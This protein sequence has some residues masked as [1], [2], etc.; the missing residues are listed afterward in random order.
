MLR[1]SS[2]KRSGSNNLCKLSLPNCKILSYADDTVLL[3]HGADWDEAR[4]YAELALVI[5]MKWLQRNLLTLNIRKTNFITFAPNSSSL[6]PDSFKLHAHQ[7]HPL[8]HSGCN[9]MQ[10]TRATNVKYLGVWIDYKLSWKEHINVTVGRVRKLIYVFKNLRAVLEIKTLRTIYFALCKSILS[11]CI[12]VWGCSA[13]SHFLR[14]ER[15]QRAILKVIT[16]KPV[17]YP[18]IELY[19]ATDVLTVRQIYILQVTLRRH[20]LLPFAGPTSGTIKRRRCDRVCNIKFCRLAT[21]KRHFHYISPIIYNR[22]NKILNIFPL[23]LRDCKPRLMNWL[24]SLSYSDT[25][26]FV[27]NCL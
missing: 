6:P 2:G 21:S 7:M 11:Y 14:L 5:T 8:D 1:S 23:T 20:T 15:A 27:K 26:E 19:A 22:L 12:V 3:I 18:T 25:E 10:I 9:C 13:K 24:K 4:T 17:L 16:F